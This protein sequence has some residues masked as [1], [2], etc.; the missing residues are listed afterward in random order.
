MRAGPI[1]GPIAEEMPEGVRRS[2][3]AESG[4]RPAAEHLPEPEG[5]TAGS[6]LLF[7]KYRLE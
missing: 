5:R 6:L 3:A 1:A 7:G 2:S 4:V